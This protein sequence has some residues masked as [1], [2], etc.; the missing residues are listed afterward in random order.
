LAGGIAHD[1]NNMLGIISG[2][3][4]YAISNLKKDDELYEVLLDVQESTKQAKG[5]TDQLMTFSKGGAPIKKVADINKIISDAAI[6]SIRGA[7]SRC[8]FELSNDLWL[9]EVDEGQI[10]QVINNLVINANQAMP[11]GGYITIRTENINIKTESGIPL[12][13][14]KYIKI[15]I[16]DQGVGISKNHLLNIFEPYFTT[17][18]KGSGLGL[19]I[20]YSIIKRHEGHITVYSEVEKGTVFN[21]Y[22]PA[23]FND[24]KEPEDQKKITHKGQGKILIM[25]DQE[26]ILKMVTRMLSKMGYEVTTAM[27]GTQAI[28]IYREA[29]DAESPFDCVILDLTVPGGMGG[30]KTIPELLKINPNVKAVVTSGYSNDPIMANYQDYGFCGVVP[31]PYTKEQLSTVLTHIF[32]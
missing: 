7:K 11:N 15:G 19:A 5:L 2:N 17:K 25:D 3:I 20:T 18:Q 22:L 28:N 10:N 12:P 21:I 14:G 31:K 13:A 27:D 4:S 24:S 30:A 29:Y 1:F 32:D 16:E 9:S 8:S 26:P 6:F 23:S